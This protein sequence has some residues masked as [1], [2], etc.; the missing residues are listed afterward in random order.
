MDGGG[1][2]PLRKMLASGEDSRTTMQRGQSDC[3]ASTITIDR[4]LRVRGKKRN[5]ANGPGD[6]LVTEMQNIPMETVYEITQWFEKRFNEEC[7]APEAWRIL[8]LVLLKKPDARLR[9]RPTRIPCDRIAQMVYLGSDRSA[10]R[11][12][13]AD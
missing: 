13:G 5:K 2:S 8:R 11:E 6:C 10:A 1:E 4:V 12:E 9:E 3:L 7:R